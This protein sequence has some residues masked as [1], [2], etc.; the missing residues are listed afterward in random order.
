MTRRIPIPSLAAMLAATTLLTPPALAAGGVLTLRDDN[1]QAEATETR[2][3]LTEVFAEAAATLD[4]AVTRLHQHRDDLIRCRQAAHDA[5]DAPAEQVIARIDGCHVRMAIGFAAEFDRLA[6]EAGGIAD[7]V[8]NA[9]RRFDQLAEAA[10]EGIAVKTA[11][12]A[13]IDIQVT[14]LDGRAQ[15]IAEYLRANPGTIDNDRALSM[16]RV[17]KDIEHMA[18]LRASLMRRVVHQETAVGRFRT[19]AANLTAGAG[20]MRQNGREWGQ[21]ADAQRAYALEVEE[22]SLINAAMSETGAVFD[23]MEG[24]LATMDAAEQVLDQALADR[25]APIVVPAQDTLT[26]ISAAEVDKMR[27]I[28]M[29]RYGQTRR[30]NGQ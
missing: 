16:R 23:R 3:A 30:G 11:E 18:G 1:P 12:I 24:V 15:V 20:L 26:F 9:A 19:A 17:L 5:E 2:K 4:T 25:P 27:T 6:G 13:E 10:R 7:G 29:D 14:D 8:A 22:V 21:H 28:F